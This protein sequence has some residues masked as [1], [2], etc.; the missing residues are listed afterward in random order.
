MDAKNR[1]P[2]TAIAY[3]Y[4]A[5][6]GLSD[7]EKSMRIKDRLLH[8]ART[9]GI[10][11]QEICGDLGGLRLARSHALRA[12]R[13]GKANVLIV[14]SLR[15]LSR[16]PAQ[17]VELVDEA[18]SGFKAARLLTCDGEFDSDKPAA[19]ACWPILRAVTEFESELHYQVKGITVH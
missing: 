8:K 11:V 19:R 17:L 2:Q 12:L 10:V 4:R 7:D 18:F 6:V 14:P 13:D 15:H 3:Y 16:K 5:C 9:E 1:K